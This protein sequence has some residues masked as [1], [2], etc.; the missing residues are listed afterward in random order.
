LEALELFLRHVPEKSGLAFVVVQHLDPTHKG[1]LAELLQR[2]TTMMVR[3]VTDGVRV[4]PDSVYV[5]PPNTEM[6]IAHGA[7]H[8]YAPATPRGH[9]LPIDFFFRSLAAD[10][11]NRAVGVLLSGMGSDGTVGLRAIKE[12]AGA[13][14]VQAPESAK[15]DPMPRSAIE[16]GLADVV[17]P[18][19]E[20]P[21]KIIGH[22]AR[23]PHGT[24]SSQPLS[25]S[26]QSS[27]EEI[28]AL[29][30][31][32]TGHDFSQ[33]K[34]ST[35]YRRIERRMGLHQL[36]R[37]PD[38][39]RYLQENPQEG[40]LLF[41]ELL[42]G[43][44]NF[45][46]DRPAWESLEKVAIPALLAERAGGGLLR[47]WTIGCSTGEEAYSIAIAFKEVLALVHPAASFSL[48][49][50]ATDLD[51]DSIDRARRG[52]YPVS[53]ARD[54]SADRLRRFFIQ[55]KDGY[56]VIPQIR[57][58][59]TFAVQNLISDPPFTRLDILSCRNLLIYLA[60]HL[61][62]K[63]WPL[64]QYSLNPGG[65]L[66]LGSAET[67]GA[68]TTAFTL[69]DS[70]ARVYRRV[71]SALHARPIEL[72]SSLEPR[73]RKAVERS[74]PMP[75]VPNLQ[76]L[77]EHVLLQR[78]SPAA[79]LTNHEGDIL[80]VSGRTGKYLE[81]AAGK[82]NWNIHAMARE[83][84]RHELASAFRQA[85]TENRR[86]VRSAVKLESGGPPR[87][88]DVTVEPLPEPPALR[89]T[90]MVVFADKVQPAAR[91][92]SR[93]KAEV[94]A[95]AAEIERALRQSEEELRITREE[96]Q[97]SQEEL[98]SAN[99]ELQSANEE[100]QSANEE[101][102]TSKEEMQSMNEELQT[103]N[104]EL[105]AN[106]DELSRASDDMRN[107]LDSTD[108]A[109]LFLDESLR[110]RRF[111]AQ[112]TK[113][114]NLIPSDLNRPITDL[115]LDMIHPELASDAR[116]VLETL[117]FKERPVTT[118]DGRWFSVRTMPYRTMANRIAGVVI[119]FVDITA[120]KTLEAALREK[121]AARDVSVQ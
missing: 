54:V 4:E 28:C 24:P 7:L 50:F 52:F 80:F 114:V 14:F 43:V 66:F 106:F 13:A 69:L 34:Q 74:A 117:V 55:E 91:K 9:R 49:I 78:Y 31:S 119:T 17:A 101:L 65:I 57:E 33:Y 44:T 113:L 1:M 56:R 77:T 25:A 11:Q 90:V 36:A 64:F 68:G 83:G 40:L 16:A 110:V 89:G 87:S 86:V 29:L 82:A 112:M 102:T 63:L 88:V 73:P 5:I 120:A 92:G 103:L 96:M 98:R 58:M 21:E 18:V 38:Y 67:I 85:L 60:P 70:K 3:Q 22:L 111:T 93:K 20:L 6:S 59:V 48:Q 35:V 26:V 97:T 8:L 51:T 75:P 47:A 76:A 100:L 108:I 10:Q 109:T 12:Q 107:L 30:R 95:Q 72:A 71:E 79:V 42:I 15:F 115:A 62:Q 94:P 53:I 45:F 105:Q 61:H 116:S 41:K 39:L 84:L 46:R 121:Q 37:M 19:Q 32:Q 99:E 27:I 23:M 81:P 2:T 118:R 104:H